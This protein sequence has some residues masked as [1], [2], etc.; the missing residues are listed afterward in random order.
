MRMPGMDGLETLAAIRRRGVE[1]PVIFMTSH[2][3]L[4]IAVEAM[5]RG[6]ADYVV[7]SMESYKKLY[8]IIKKV[9]DTSNAREF[10]KGS[11]VYPILPHFTQSPSKADKR[12]RDN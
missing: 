9:L 12:P 1:T 6:A 4:T 5:K 10:N 3:D 2:D 8:S 11:D 7:K